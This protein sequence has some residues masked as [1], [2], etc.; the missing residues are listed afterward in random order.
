M[1]S[2]IIVALD[3]SSAAEASAL[4]QTL[5]GAAQSYKIGLQLL[6]AEGPALVREL[7]A[8]AGSWT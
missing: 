7:P 5:G 6:A 1:E 3:F 4:V 2:P 8:K